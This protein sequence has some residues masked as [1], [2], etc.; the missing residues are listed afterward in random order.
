MP[1]V[2]RALLK[3]RCTTTKDSER[4]STF[5]CRP[6]WMQAL[7]IHP[8]AWSI[9]LF[10]QKYLLLQ[11]FVEGDKEFMSPSLLCAPSTTTNMHTNVEISIVVEQGNKISLFSNPRTLGGN[12][13]ERRYSWCKR[14]RIMSNQILVASCRQANY[15]G[16]LLL[17][18]RGD[19]TKG[20]IGHD[21]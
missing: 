14:P 19:G 18:G 17:R 21:K 12:G 3:E 4:M 8:I 16:M 9:E 2:L 15:G 11:E 5:S 10:V 13:R 6:V 20:S 1:M 7:H